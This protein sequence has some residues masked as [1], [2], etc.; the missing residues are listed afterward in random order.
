[1]KE[2]KTNMK[3]MTGNK[4][5]IMLIVMLF[6]FSAMAA[7]PVPNIGNILNQTEPP[8]DVLREKQEIPDVKPYEKPAMEKD[9]IGTLFVKGFTVVGNNAVASDMLNKIANDSENINRDMTLSGIEKV[10]AQITKYYRSLG[11][12]VAKAYVPKQQVKDGIVEIVVLEGHYGNFNLTNNSYVD[13]ATVQNML[14]NVKSN[15]EVHI[16]SLER[17]M[18][19]INDTPGAVITKANIQPGSV[20][21]SSDFNITAGA[22]QRINGYVIAD[23]YGLRYTGKNRFIA[24][25]GVNSPLGIGDRLDISGLVSNGSDLKNGRLAYSIPLGANGLREEISYSRTTYSLT[26]E[27]D[28]LDASGRSDILELALSYPVIRSRL[29]NLNTSVSMSMNK[30]KDE[31]KSMYVDSTQY[32]KALKATVNYSNIYKLFGLNASTALTGIYTYGNFHYDDEILEAMDNESVNTTGDFNKI[33]GQAEQSVVFSNSV[34][35]NTS[36]AFQQ[37]L[38]NK[39]LDGSEDFS[40]GGPFG[41]R[42]F[43][44]SEKSAENGYILNAEL[45][46]NLP[47]YKGFA[48]KFSV[49]VDNARAST[50]NNVTGEKSRT[51][52]DAGIGFYENYKD[53]FLKAYYAR[54]LGATKVESEPDYKSRVLVQAGMV[55]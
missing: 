46:W 16:T 6:S 8:K 33:Y 49:F 55:F 2:N 37:A 53:F 15:E 11:Y 54:I 3:L 28:A 44:T 14:D 26:E 51:L 12:F 30:M 32:S 20:V 50:Q 31:I 19:L 29:E 1:M 17:S 47:V 18:L 13:D 35:L 23:N 39:N 5:N 52:T 48:T 36:L 4:I 22:S 40:I 10:A 45:F 7:S 27:Y 43:P 21:G 34:S 24:G 42:A 9:D 25:L 41:V 38:G